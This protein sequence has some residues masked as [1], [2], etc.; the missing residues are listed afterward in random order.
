MLDYSQIRARDFNPA[1]GVIERENTS[2]RNFEHRTHAGGVNLNGLFDTGSISHNL[3]LGIDLKEEMRRRP[4]S[5]LSSGGINN[6]I[7]YNLQF[8]RA[9]RATDYTKTDGQ[10]QRIRSIGGYAQDNINLTENLIYALGL[11]YEYYDQIG[12]NL[13]KNGGG[14]EVKTDS[15]DGKFIYQTGLIYLLT[16]EWSVYGNYAQSFRPQISTSEDMGHL[17]P[18]EGISTEVGTKFQNDEITAT[19]ALFNIDKKNVAYSINNVTYAAGKVNSR[20]IELDANG[21]VTQG[22]SLGAS[23]AY[24]KTET[25]KDEKNKW[26]VGKP[27][28]ATPKN[29]ASLMANYDFSH[30]GLKGFRIGG[31][32]RYFGSW[33]AYSSRGDSYKMPHAVT[34]DAFAGYT[35]KI[36]GYET[37]FAFNV[38][39][40]TNKIYY[41]SYNSEKANI[42]SA[43][44]GYARQFML[45]ASVKF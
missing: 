9:T 30:L 6:L 29:Q 25:K 16:P 15:S 2:F 19:L 27:L 28:D 4:V 26:K 7:L 22:L 45:T 21:R 11:R 18:E 42:L 17:D 39:N 13:N 20:G 33:N 12:G 8:G 37:N 34:Y 5:A 43:A 36:A 41:T 40:L 14:L 3:L 38:K 24:T 1:T 23:Y 32:A 35:T 44:M 10:Y 31:A